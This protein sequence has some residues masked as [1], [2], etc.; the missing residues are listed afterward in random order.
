[1]ATVSVLISQL[2]TPKDRKIRMILE[3]LNTAIRDL[4]KR[5][6]IVE[7][8][9]ADVLRDDGLF[10]QL[11]QRLV[12]LETHKIFRP[13]VV[14]VEAEPAETE[15]AV[16][17]EA[18]TPAEEVVAEVEEPVAEV[19]EPVA[20]V[21][22]PVAE[23]EEPVAKVEEPV[24]EV[25]E[26]VAEAEEP[27]AEVAAPEEPAAEPAAQPAAEETPIEKTLVA[28]MGVLQELSRRV[29]AISQ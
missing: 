8:S 3:G 27:V 21:E 9:V 29:D 26:P 12:A 17:A 14:V 24:A 19:A 5:V 18:E 6:D 7:R 23:A 13:D 15:S 25:E 20:E 2:N 22:E 16:A 11:E 10:S 28:I 1:M 4:T